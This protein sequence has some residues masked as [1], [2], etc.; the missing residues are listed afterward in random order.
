M[1]H[2]E[3]SRI[4]AFRSELRRFRRRTELATADALLT[5]QRYDLLLMIHS[6]GGNEGL[7]VTE[8][9]RLMHMQQPAVTE[10]VKR[11]EDAK[12]VTRRRSP[13][14][15]R[16]SLLRLTAKGERRLQKAIAALRDDRERLAT[17]LAELDKR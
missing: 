7:R 9:C 17:A 11:A 6:S 14:D 16:S 4:A 10:L 2:A 13:D 1:T 15:G 5:P 8:L 12:L 3:L